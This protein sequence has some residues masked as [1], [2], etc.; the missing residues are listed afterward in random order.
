MLKHNSWAICRQQPYNFKSRRSFT[1]SLIDS[2][3]TRTGE[4]QW[5]H[6][7]WGDAVL[8]CWEK[9]A[10]LIANQAGVTFTMAANASGEPL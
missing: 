1:P 3:S 7:D 6:S 4:M 10:S 9:K 2:G 8:Y 5:L